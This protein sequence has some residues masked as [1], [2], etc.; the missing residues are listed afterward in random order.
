MVWDGNTKHFTKLAQEPEIWSSSTLYTKEMKQLRK[1]WFANWLQENKNYT[2][3]NIL[4]FHKNEDLGTK[5]T[6]PKMKRNFVETV[7]VTSI[8]KNESEV[9][10]TYFDILNFSNVV[11]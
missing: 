1:D 9:D 5:E 8:Q 4:A 3:E 2:Q 11:V 6:A 7:S 10:F